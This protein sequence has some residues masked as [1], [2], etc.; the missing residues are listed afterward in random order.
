MVKWPNAKDRSLLLVVVDLLCRA[1]ACAGQSVAVTSCVSGRAN[2]P[3]PPQ[4]YRLKLHVT[5][6]QHITTCQ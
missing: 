5:C 2:L 3:R 6:L 1:E 4:R